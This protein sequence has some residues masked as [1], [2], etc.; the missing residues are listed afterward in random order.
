MIGHKLK[1]EQAEGHS[2]ANKAS[3][4]YITLMEMEESALDAWLMLG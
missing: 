3:R 1:Q 4:E 2:G